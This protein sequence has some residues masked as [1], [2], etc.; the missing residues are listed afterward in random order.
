MK[1]T[2]LCNEFLAVDAKV[3]VVFEEKQAVRKK[4]RQVELKAGDS[5]HLFTAF[6]V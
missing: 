5:R 1:K 6:S 3:R 4:V 2:D